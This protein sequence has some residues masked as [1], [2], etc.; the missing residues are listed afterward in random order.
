MSGQRC[1][2][3]VVIRESGVG[4][5]NVKW[6]C[7]CDCGNE[8]VVAGCDLRSGHTKSCGC[9]RVSVSKAK[10]VT[11][12]MRGSPEYS[13]WNSMVQRCTNKRRNRYEAYGGRGISVCKKWLNFDG[14][15]SDMGKR[16]SEKHQIDRIDNDGNYELE[17]CRWVLPSVNSRNRRSTKLSEADVGRILSLIASGKTRTAIAKEYGVSRH[18]IYGVTKSTARRDAGI[19][20]F[21]GNTWEGL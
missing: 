9:L 18:A 16:P 2:Q 11:H 7:I 4:K 21:L 8:T 15:I 17:N 1:G 5:K 19:M 14:F 12:G 20:A 6:F 10:G 13:V 3:L